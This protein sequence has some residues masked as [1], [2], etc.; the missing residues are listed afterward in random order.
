MKFEIINVDLGTTVDSII[1]DD[2]E[3]LTGKNEADIESILLATRQK[4]DKTYT[5]RAQKQAVNEQEQLSKHD[6]LQRS[7][8]LLKEAGNNML[9]LQEIAAPA[10]PIFAPSASF[11]SI[12]NRYLR[13]VHNGEYMLTKHTKQGRAVYRLRKF[14]LE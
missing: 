3:R 5:K 1:T 13:D 12:F 11:V 2:I 6:A 4:I 9:T 7:F 8:Q 10:A 14:S